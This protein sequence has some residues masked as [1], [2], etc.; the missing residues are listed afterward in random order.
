MSTDPQ[1]PEC[2]S[3]YAYLDGALWNCPECGHAWNPQEADS[4]AN[5]QADDSVRDAHGNV[6]ATGD[7]VIVMKD[8]KVKGASSA[9]KA[10]TKVKNIRLVEASDGHDISCNIDGFGSMFLKSEFVKKA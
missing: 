10:G 5:D 4:A 7:T 1:C 6:L 8:L 2:R 9:V 3:E